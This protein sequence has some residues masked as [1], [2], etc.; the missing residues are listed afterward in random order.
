MT[1]RGWRGKGEVSGGGDGGLGGWEGWE[2]GGEWVWC[3][4]RR[5][6]SAR[7]SLARPGSCGGCSSTRRGAQKISARAPHNRGV[8]AA[9]AAATAVVA[10][11][12]ARVSVGPP[13]VAVGGVEGREGERRRGAG[14]GPLT[15]VRKWPSRGR[16]ACPRASEGAGRVA[17]SRVGV[18][19]DGG[20][21]WASVRGGAGRAGGV[22]W[23]PAPLVVAGSER[24]STTT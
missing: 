12:R 4:G 22:G 24:C 9:G 16:V 1:T 3:R 23:A 14:D 13:W 7:G 20:C 5:R 10:A 2:R 18:G 21:A 19:V 8:N 6:R 11:P 17:G 15:G